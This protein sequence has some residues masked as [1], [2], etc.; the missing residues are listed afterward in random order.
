VRKQRYS[1]GRSMQRREGQVH[2]RIDEMGHIIGGREDIRLE[3]RMLK[4]DWPS[5]GADHS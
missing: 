3:E 2:A 4:E 5:G 1:R